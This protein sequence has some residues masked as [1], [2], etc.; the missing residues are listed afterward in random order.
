MRAWRSSAC[1]TRSMNSARFARPVTASWNAWCD[2]WS[3]NALRSETSRVLST[4]PSD[5]LVL[6]QVRSQRLDVQPEV[7]HV[8]HPELGEPGH[9]V[10]LV[11][12]GG[13]ELQDVRPVVRMDQFGE[14]RALELARLVAEH[15]FDRRAHVADRRVRIDHHDDVGGVLDERG[16][17]RLA[18]TADEVLREHRTLERE[19]DLRG[20]RLETVARGSRQ[21]VRAAHDEQGAELAL[22]EQGDH[23]E[24]RRPVRHRERDREIGGSGRQHRPLSLQ[25]LA[26]AFGRHD[27]HDPAD[28][29]V[30][31]LGRGDHREPI[32][33]VRLEAH[34]QPRA[35]LLDEGRDGAHGRDVDRLAVRRRDERGAGAAQRSS[36]RKDS[37]SVWTSPD[38]RTTTSR[39]SVVVETVTIHISAPSPRS[40]WIARTACGT[41]AAVPMRIDRPRVTRTSCSGAGAGADRLSIEWCKAAAPHRT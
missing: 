28:L 24:L 7:V 36:R 6:E 8:L 41:S 18:L 32:G 10:A 25:H 9:P 22:H 4:I 20:Q 29:P 12:A 19:G 13:E 16:E 35:S 34:E 31:A 3:S 1:S 27:V 15:A 11:A 23:E 21:R 37:P 40:N 30:V 33:A 39:N 14:L 26:V 17:A 38:I 2:S 5:V